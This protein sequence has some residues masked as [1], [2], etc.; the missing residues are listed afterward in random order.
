MAFVVRAAPFIE[1]LCWLG[2]ICI[3][4]VLATPRMKVAMR[5]LRRLYR[6]AADRLRVTRMIAPAMRAARVPCQR[7][8]TRV[9]QRILAASS[10]K[11]MVKRDAILEDCYPKVGKIS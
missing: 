9:Q 5:A 3:I 10:D 2:S 6:R 8:W 7:E 1:A 4:M 11:S